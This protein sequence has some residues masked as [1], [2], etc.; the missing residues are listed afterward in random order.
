MKKYTIL[1]LVLLIHLVT[2][3]DPACPDSLC[4]IQPNGD[5][6]WTYLH[7]DEFYHWRSTIDGHVIMRNSNNYFCYAVVNGDSLH[8]SEMV[9]HNIEE[10][11]VLEQ[12]SIS[13]I[14]PITKQFIDA[15]IQQT[16][17]SVPNNMLHFSSVQC[18]TND[19][20]TQ[21]PV[22]GTRKVL[23]VLMEYPDYPFR[24]TQAQFDSLMN[25]AIGSVEQNAG[26]VR[27]YY[28]EN[29]YGQLCVETTVVGPY[30]TD[31]NRSYYN[32][33]P[34]DGDIETI[35]TL[36]TEAINKASYDVDFST[37]DGDADSYVDC[38]HIVF[39]GEGLSSGLDSYIWSHQF[40]LEFPTFVGRTGFLKY[41]ITPELHKNGQLASLGTICHELGHIFGAPDYYDRNILNGEFFAMGKYDIMC[42][43]SHNKINNTITPA[44]HNPYTKCHTFGWDYPTL[45]TD[46][47]EDYRLSSSTTNRNH[48]YRIEINTY[49]EHFLLENRTK[50]KFNS[51]IPNAGLLIYHI[52][53]FVEL[54]TYPN[55]SHPLGLY[56][57]NACA[58]SN[59]NSNP[60]SYGTKDTERAYPGNIGDKTM[61]TNT[62]I[63]S[64]K[65]WD[66]SESDV[67][68]CFIQKES[69][70]DI[71]FT[72]N[73]EIQG[74]SQLCGIR[75][76]CVSGIV[77]NQDVI[78][79]SYS[80]NITEPF[81]YP[82]LR[83]EE[84][85]TG[86]CVPIER[87]NTINISVGPIIPEDTT[88]IMSTYGIATPIVGD[89]HIGTAKLYA[90]ITSG[91]GTYQM[92]KDIVMPE[93]ATPSLLS[94]PTF[95]I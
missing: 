86:A 8:P 12:E 76:Y 50:E 53:P 54:M 15:E 27:Q 68:I 33:S 20:G 84:G 38:I 94:P 90:T 19:Y 62:S 64:A 67:N 58:D 42:N 52:R 23:T 72:V 30:L 57:V 49:G 77:P 10:R 39:A 29:S 73:P 60:Y 88:M 59:P 66:G 82:A 11:S 35:R 61:F 81:R 85:K 93:Y 2:V 24:K 14:N 21:H 87:G 65:A 13:T 44:H 22:V 78:T 37:L 9:A 18:K 4:I 55:D 63:P 69:N 32:W 16:Y 3:A 41:I 74:P 7:G 91:S 40:E 79:W 47:N 83:F 36:V 45:I 17:N 6:L 70:G 48:F 25:Q 89:P 26:S 46:A 34:T 31:Y 28:L 71:T 1:L 80:T 75:D 95:A 92:E 51:A 5:T 43:G 56:L